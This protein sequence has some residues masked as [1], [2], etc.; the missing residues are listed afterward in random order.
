ML[1]ADD[2][3]LLREGIIAVA[4]AEPD[5]EVVGEAADG[6]EALA[7]FRRLL[8]DITLLDLRMPDMDGIKVITAIRA[9]FP[10]A[11]LIVLT[12]YSGEV[13]ALRAIR[14][15]ASGYLLKNSMRIELIDVIRKVH[16]GNKHIPPEIV[17]EIMIDAEKAH[18]SPRELEVLRLVA[19]GKANKEVARHLGVVEETI[20][21]HLKSIFAKL[22]VSDRTHA[23]TIAARRGIIDL[24]GPT[25]F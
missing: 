2:H 20:K 9:E 5:I 21:A 17:D 4:S 11:R 18:L 7:S 22:E 1:I 25:E 10:S 6:H 23:V 19:D 15:G 3:P 14:A 13:Q 8:P 12:T 24:S 16:A